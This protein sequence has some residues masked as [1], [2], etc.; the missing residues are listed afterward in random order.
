[1]ASMRARLSGKQPCRMTLPRAVR[2]STSHWVRARNASTSRLLSDLSE[3]LLSGLLL[4][5]LRAD[6]LCRPCRICPYFIMYGLFFIM[7]VTWHSIRSYFATLRFIRSSSGYSICFISRI[8][9]YC[10]DICRCFDFL[11]ETSLDIGFI[12]I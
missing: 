9:R 8:K 5:P 7:S 3:H 6:R 2:R 1:M 10:C 4:R 11:I 12:V